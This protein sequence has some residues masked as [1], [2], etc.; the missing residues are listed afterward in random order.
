MTTIQ[1]IE[2]LFTWLNADPMH[3]I[4]FVVTLA[5]AISALTPTPAP[6]TWQAKLYRVIDVCAINIGHAK[7]TGQTPIAFAEQVAAL[8]ASKSAT[9]TKTGDSPVAENKE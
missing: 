6:G 8:L 2:A 3:A 1:S 4:G 7:S 5:S 9:A